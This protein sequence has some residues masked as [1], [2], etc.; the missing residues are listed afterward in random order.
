MTPSLVY[1]HGKRLTF[2]KPFVRKQYNVLA[3]FNRF[4]EKPLGYVRQGSRNTFQK[5]MFQDLKNSIYH[6]ILTIFGGDKHD[7][8]FN[9]NLLKFRDFVVLNVTEHA[10][11][12]WKLPR[13]FRKG[14]H[15]P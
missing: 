13:Q 6:P 15:Q 5:K 11:I 1:M 10:Q 7:G 4:C 14:K 3:F 8:G 2:R 9:P 12:V